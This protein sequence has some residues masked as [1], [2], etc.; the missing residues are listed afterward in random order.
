M[1]EIQQNQLKRN[2]SFVKNINSFKVNLQDE[3]DN[4]DNNFGTSQDIESETGTPHNGSNNCHPSTNVIVTSVEEKKCD[5]DI[6]SSK[7]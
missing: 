7:T 4:N 2:N 5:K 3:D 6:Q 1:A